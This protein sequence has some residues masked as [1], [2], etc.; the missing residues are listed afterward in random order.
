MRKNT[1][2]IWGCGLIILGIIFALNALEIVK[3]NIFFDGW[4]TLF[5]IVPAL[6]GVISSQDK[7]GDIIM[8]VIG[9]FLLLASQDLI[10]FELIW[11]LMLPFILICFGVSLIFKNFLNSKIP[12][13]TLKKEGKE[14]FAIFSDQ[15]FA[16]D[17]N[18]AAGSK[19][20]AVFG[21]L[22]LDLSD[23]KIKEDIVISALA[24]FGGVTIVLPENVDVKITASSV[25]GGANNKRKN[26][27]S[28]FKV[29]VYI[30]AFTMFGGV[31]IK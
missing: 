10:K 22:K 30:N 31:D 17:Q 5:I 14:Y 25:F 11:K 16:L 3:I 4:W 23:A 2:L 20:T 6:K 7:T 8:F 12:K 9:I 24:V 15:K 21:G 27:G 19:L 29:T 26:K 28:D 13:K 1:N 18:E